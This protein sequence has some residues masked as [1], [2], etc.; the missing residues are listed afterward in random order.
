[1]GNFLEKA[2]PRQIDDRG[3]M[4]HTGNLLE[5]KKFVEEN[6][7]LREK[8][9]TKKRR[10]RIFHLYGK[11]PRP[12]SLGLTSIKP[13]S[14]VREGEGGIGHGDHGDQ[15]QK[16]TDAKSYFTAFFYDIALLC[17]IVSDGHLKEFHTLI[18]ADSPK[19]TRGRKLD[20]SKL[21]SYY[22][23]VHKKLKPREGASSPLNKRRTPCQRFLKTSGSSC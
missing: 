10:S 12:P 1:M 4:P 7:L 16:Q 9:S 8:S 17:L 15:T 21:W 19:N 13:S 22:E 5:A 23:H 6:C 20:S 2:K 11:F 18:V 14:L 3:K